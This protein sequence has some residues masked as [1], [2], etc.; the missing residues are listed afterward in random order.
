[1][2]TLDII[3]ILTFSTFIINQTFDGLLGIS[4]RLLHICQ[5]FQ[6]Y[7]LLFRL[8]KIMISTISDQFN[9][10]NIAFIFAILLLVMTSFSIYIAEMDENKQINNI[11]D[12]FW[13]GF[14][15]LFT[16]G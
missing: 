12:A 2:R 14:I 1:M 5:V 8:L 16:I 10:L 7:R 15:T 13:F 4:L 3:G 11:F 6:L 9:Q